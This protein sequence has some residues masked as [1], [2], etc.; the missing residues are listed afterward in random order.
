MSTPP[1][2]LAFDASDSPENLRLRG[3]DAY[4]A[5]QLET[6]VELYSRCLDTAGYSYSGTTPTHAQMQIPIQ[7][8]TQRKAGAEGCP[9][10]VLALGNRAA[11]HLTLKQFK[12]CAA[13]ASA[14]LEM[15]PC[16]D[17]YHYR[18][19]LALRGLGAT[20]AAAEALRE[21]LA[22]CPDSASL[23]R[24]KSSSTGPATVTPTST[25]ATSRN[26]AN[27]N[28]TGA[29]AGKGKGNKS[30]SAGLQAWGSGSGGLP[31]YCEPCDDG[32]DDDDDGKRAG[33]AAAAA[34]GGG[35]RPGAGGKGK[36]VRGA[37]VL[38]TTAAD[39][40]V[41]TTCVSTTCVCA[42]AATTA[43]ATAAVFLLLLLPYY[44]YLTLLLSLSLLTTPLR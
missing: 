31:L 14:A 12:Q 40:C 15:Q 30:I 5:A 32:D 29:G 1:E 33:G 16:N 22:A 10:V 6:A 11:C 26:D 3:N 2:A 9:D 4:K 44:Q 21:A 24:L 28:C 38:E 13:D 17:K 39:Q 36:E 25:G 41:S 23:R 37:M 19:V 43:T 18:R 34:R 8:Q 42:A 20:A 35:A 27:R 7:T